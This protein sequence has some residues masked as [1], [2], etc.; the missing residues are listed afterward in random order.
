MFW[1]TR[2]SSVATPPS[3]PAPRVGEA[4]TRSKVFPKFLMAVARQPN[5]VLLDLGPVVGPNIA[6]FG[7]RL[8]C[9]IVIEDVFATI[10]RAAAAGER[11][12][13]PAVLSSQLAR[14]NASVDG[15]LCWDVFDYLDRG[16]GRMLAT[17]LTALLRPGGALYG[18]FGTTDIELTHYSR[19]TFEAEDV[20]RVRTYPATPVRRTVLVTR[21]VIRMFEG[22]AVAE[23]V[24]L[25]TSARECLFRKP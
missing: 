7:D 10:E 8:A 24:L 18:F 11:A 2:K 9:K 25:K 13:L 4:L 6:F 12:S 19:V 16:A 14:E 1:N 3:P 5:P 17:R 15:I 23:S 21:D 22:L 20:L